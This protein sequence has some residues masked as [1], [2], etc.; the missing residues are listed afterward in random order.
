MQEI[1]F[2]RITELRKNLALL[3]KKL[4][5]KVSLLGKKLA[6]E[7]NALEEYEAAIVFGAMK[8]GFSA[9]KAL[10]LK[11]EGMIFRVI[12]IKKFSR[13]K[14]LKEVRA[15]II[16]KHGKTKKTI[17]SIAGCHLIIRDNEVGL[18]GQSESIEELMTGIENLIRGT[19]QTNTY[20][21]LEKLNTKRKL[22]GEI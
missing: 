3:G 17:E 9:Q 22:R 6:F 19:K 1:Y 21:Y 2:H 12:N 18:I 5:V 11:E 10:L 13:K 16:G 8:F 4:K 20:R 7:G 14:N 15:R